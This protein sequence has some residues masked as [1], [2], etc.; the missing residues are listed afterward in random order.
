VREDFGGEIKP[1]NSRFTYNIIGFIYRE[2]SSSKFYGA[3]REPFSGLKK[4]IARFEWYILL[5][6]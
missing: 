2:R 6:T 4:V 3:E 1:G 5:T